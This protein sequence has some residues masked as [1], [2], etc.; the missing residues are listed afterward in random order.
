[1]MLRARDKSLSSVWDYALGREDFNFPATRRLAGVLKGRID[2]IHCHNLHGGYFDLR[3]LPQLSRQFPTILTLHDTWLLSGHCAYSLGCERWRASCGRCPDLNIYPAI[4]RDNTAGNWRRKRNI[5]A[6]SRLF[7]A[8]PCQWLMK[9]VKE[10]MLGPLAEEMRVIPNGVDTFLFCPADNPTA[11]RDQLR[12]A[13]S[14]KVVLFVASGM[15]HNRFKDYQTIRLCID[16]L[17][18]D[19]QIGPLLLLA[20][21][22]EGA[23][24]TVGQTKIEFVPYI[25]DHRQ[26]VKYFQVANVYVH[27][28]RAEIFPNSILEALSCWVPVVA[29]A[30]GGIPE[31][32][33]HGR[34]GF[35]LPQANAVALA[36]S[37]RT[38]LLDDALRERVGR[39]AREVA[40]RQF[41]IDAQCDAY[42]AWYE[43]LIEQYQRD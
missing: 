31:Q 32:I 9:L 36:R 35:V 42:L 6:K 40:L 39:Q 4:Q 13:P 33:Q 19:K 27:A 43:Q 24:Q 41:N 29:T 34:T 20:L 12:I 1:L 28:A 11:I 26:V 10:S 7:V 37:I 8:T 15:Q 16:Y 38:L 3:V 14:V 25:N 18:A 2:V 23:P 30:T 17:A 5:Y 22:G 21:G